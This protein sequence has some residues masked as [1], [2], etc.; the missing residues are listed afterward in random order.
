MMVDKIKISPRYEDISNITNYT[1]NIVKSNSSIPFFPPCKNM[2][3]VSGFGNTLKRLNGNAKPYS[4]FDWFYKSNGNGL[5]QSGGELQLPPYGLWGGFE[6]EL[7]AVHVINEELKPIYLGYTVG[8]DFTNTGLRRK[9][10]Q[11]QN[12]SHLSQTMVANFIIPEK[13]PEKVKLR[14]KIIRDKDFIWDSI[15][16]AG[17][18]N[19]WVSCNELIDV[20]LRNQEI[21]SKGMVFYTL[22][23]AVVSSDKAGVQLQHG[24]RININLDEISIGLDATFVVACT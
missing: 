17:N 8:L 14:T 1:Q 18:S 20:L 22:T 16:L 19:M 5:R 6:T 24:D 9:Y 23:G 10:P 13:F 7:I 2:A 21:L 11:F 3:F 4:H 12:L 15:D